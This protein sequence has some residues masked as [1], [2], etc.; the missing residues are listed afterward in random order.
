MKITEEQF[1][2]YM[3]CPA[4]FEM[5]HIRKIPVIENV[6]HI[7]LLD[8]VA[9]YFYLNILNG[10]IPTTG[11]LKNKWDSICKDY[12][13]QLDPKKVLEGFSLIMKLYHWAA[14]ERI[15]VLD[16]DTPYAIHVEDTEITGNME[17]V[18]AAPNSGYELLITR[19]SNRLPDQTLIDMKLD[20]TLNAYAFQKMN[21]KPVSGIKI[22]SVKHSKDFYTRR[23]E[24]DFKR[25]ETAIKNVGKSIKEGIYYPREGMCSTCPLKGYCKYWNS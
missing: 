18:L 21:N 2:D 5:K 10:R 23:T 22:R 25:L 14:S 16:I 7:K 9:K 19:F 1:F 15:V 6:N 4:Y 20:I 12:E 17:T 8:K 24:E 11:E 3:H 13:D